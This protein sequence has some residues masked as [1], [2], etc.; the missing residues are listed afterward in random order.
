MSVIPYPALYGVPSGR[1]FAVSRESAAAGVGSSETVCRRFIPPRAA[2]PGPVAS[3]VVGVG[4]RATTF[5]SPSS[6]PRP[7]Q[8]RALG[9]GRPGEEE[10]TTSVVGSTDLRRPYKAPLRIEPDAGKVGEDV[11]KPKSKVVCDVLKDRD[12]G[13]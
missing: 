4:S 8:S 9:V 2:C 7:R 11:G 6:K 10:E 12:A 3:E 13:S 1:K 5:G